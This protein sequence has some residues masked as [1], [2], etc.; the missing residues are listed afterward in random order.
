MDLNLTGRTALITGAASGIGKAT[1]AVMAAEGARIVAVDRDKE[2]LNDAAGKLPVAPGGLSHVSITAD[3]S[4]AEGV[5]A[6]MR[7]ALDAAGGTIDI[8]VS[9]AGQCEWRSLDELTDEN[10]YAT[11]ELNF[12]ATVRAVRYLL[13]G[14]MARQ[15]GV[16]RDHGVRPGP[17]ARAQSRRLPGI[18]GRAGRADEGA[19]HGGQPL[20]PGQ[21]G[22]AR[23]DLDTA[24][25]AARGDRG[26]PRPAAPAAPA[27]GR[28]P[29]SCPSGTSPSA[30]SASHTRWPTSSRSLPPTPPRSSPALST[31]ST[32]AASAACCDSVS[33]GPAL[34]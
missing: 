2:G 17:P 34:C 4:S 22:R 7:E 15:L 3:L 12:M 20:R 27:G 6:A 31:G 8:F 5:E 21:R 19:G 18:Q 9:N 24:M 25:V 23:A 14:M 10:W 11:L 16:D 29:T 30:G 1:A 33:P 32:A 28:S 13:P 26:Q